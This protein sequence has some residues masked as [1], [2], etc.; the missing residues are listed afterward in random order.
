MT[1]PTTKPRARREKGEGTVFFHEGRQR[2]I[3]TLDLGKDA[4]G[5]RRRK[6][7][8]AVKRADVVKSLRD[9]KRQHE[10]GKPLVAANDTVAALLADYLEKGLPGSVRTANTRAGYVWAI[11]KHISPAIGAVRLRDLTPDHV[12]AMLTEKRD[13]GLGH[14]SLVQLHRVLTVALRWAERRGRIARN[15]AALCDTPV[16]GAHRP[17]RAFLPAEITSLLAVVDQVDDQAAKNPRGNAVRLAAAWCVMAGMGLRPGECFALSW[18]DVDFDAP[19]ADGN[20]KG[21]L[22]V[23]G[24]LV[25]DQAT[26]SLYV[27]PTKTAKSRRLLDM[28]APVAE[29][30]RTH[31]RWQRELRM[32]V[33]ADWRIGLSDETPDL[34]FTNATGGPLDPSA[35]RRRFKRLCVAAGLSDNRHPHELRHSV[36]S[37]LVAQGVPLTAVSDLLGHESTRT[38]DQV[39]RHVVVASQSAALGTAALFGAPATGATG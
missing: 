35:V 9:A 11:E 27:G 33:G 24:S 32:A 18:D 37:F 6:T 25:R 21:V 22:H 5:R 4:Q 39:Y 30:L 7:F 34:V 14:R 15:V 2:W 38:T 13:S 10:D 19:H 16:D 23:K 20:G 8:T 1:K 29:A 31:R 3:A 12:E 36:T 26:N 28:P 17:S